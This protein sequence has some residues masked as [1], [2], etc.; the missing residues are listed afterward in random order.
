MTSRICAIKQ[1]Q[2]D[3][4]T[5]SIF[6]PEDASLLPEP[7]LQKKGEKPLTSQGTGACFALPIGA[8][9]TLSHRECII[10]SQINSRG[11]FKAADNHAVVYEHGLPVRLLLTAG[12]ASD[13]ATTPAL[14][15]GLPTSQAIIECRGYDWLSSRSGGRSRRAGANSYP[16]RGAQAGGLRNCAH[17]QFQRI[18]LTG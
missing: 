7:A 12:H 5:K 11:H 13:K 10:L 15:E 6:W 3:S 8:P 16:R 18:G 17:N 4:L 9:P 14:V 2:S 1:G